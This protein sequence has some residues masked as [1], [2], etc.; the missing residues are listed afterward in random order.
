MEPALLAMLVDEVVQTPYVGQDS[1]GKPV[2]GSPFTR[3]ARIEYMTKVVTNA[4]GQERTSTT[5]LFLNGDIPISSRDKLVL[6]DGTAPASPRRR[7]VIPRPGRTTRTRRTPRR[8]VAH[9][10]W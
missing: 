7:Q 5:I 1:Y 10:R 3:P 8:P 2:Y 9:G 4:A 6:P